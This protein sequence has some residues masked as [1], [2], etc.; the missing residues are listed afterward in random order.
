M[1]LGFTLVARQ[2]DDWL[3]EDLREPR[4]ESAFRLGNTSD[5]AE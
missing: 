5:T 2:A 1:N 4:Q 3:S